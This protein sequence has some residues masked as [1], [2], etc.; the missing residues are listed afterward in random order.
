MDHEKRIFALGFFD[1]VHRGHQV[2]LSECTR[3]A[4]RMG[5][6]TAAITF[7]GYDALLKATFPAG[8]GAELI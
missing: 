3:L 5:C 8:M 1:G 7:E 6:E 4:E 2:L